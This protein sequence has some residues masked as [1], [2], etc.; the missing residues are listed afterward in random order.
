MSIKDPLAPKLAQIKEI[1][2]ETPDVKTFRVRFVDPNDHEAF[3]YMPGQFAELSVFGVGEATISITSTITRPEFIEFCVKNVGEVSS[4]LH[5]LSPDDIIGLRGPYGN[6]FPLDFLAGKNLI[7]IG[8]GFALAPLRGLINYCVDHRDDFNKFSLIYGARSP[9]DL[10]FKDEIF[11]NWPKVKDF[12]CTI[13]VDKGD[14][15]WSGR[16]GFV[17]AVLREVAPSPVDAVTITCGPPIMI[18]FVLEALEEL[19]FAHEQIITTL[20]MRMKCGVGQCGRCNIGEKYVCLD[21][22]VFSLAQLKT[23]TNEY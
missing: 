14:E 17:P 2:T 23:M 3:K 7:F 21:G 12:D 5:G 16:V 4:A 22:P 18:K 8:G 10:C 20:E 11:K 13:T 1:I 9:E 15:T 6:N 19:G